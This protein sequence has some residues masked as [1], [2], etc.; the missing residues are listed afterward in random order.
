MGGLFA[1]FS[2]NSDG[3]YVVD[4]AAV[5]QMAAVQMAIEQ[6]NNKNDGV[7]DHLLPNTQVRFARKRAV[8]S[9]N[10]II[11]RSLR[12]ATLTVQTLLPYVCKAGITRRRQQESSQ[13]CT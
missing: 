1:Q 4:Q 9:Q 8:I 10:F 7:Y 5:R 11:F 2:L 12:T 13:T 6:V 3:K